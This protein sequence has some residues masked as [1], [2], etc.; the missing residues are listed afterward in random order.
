[1]TSPPSAEELARALHGRRRGGGWLC[2]CP[3]HDDHHP[4]LSIAEGDGRRTL[5]KCWGGCSQDSVLDELR[6]RNLWPARRDGGTGGWT[7]GRTGRRESRA[8][9]ANADARRGSARLVDPMKPWRDAAPFAGGC[10][11]DS[12]L[13]SRG[14]E[15]AEHETS[16]LRSASALWHWPTG[17]HWPA[18]V[19]RA[20]LGD[21]VELAAHMT[22][23]RRDGSSK[24]PLG[25][26]V[27][28]FP[29][30]GRTAGGGVWFGTVED[31]EREF[32]VGEGIESTLSAMRI[33]HCAA[34]CAA[35]S[36]FGI[37][38]LVLP[39]S[40]RRI[41]IF[42]DHDALGQGLAAARE[43]WRRWRA[44]GREVA[45]SI[46]SSAGEDANDVWRRRTA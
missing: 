39:A 16:N 30:G 27:R 19:A 41:R 40:V 24:A 18:M 3:A 9:S 8:A 17:T 12:Y 45:V 2:K 23:L 42:A 38:R 43:A 37:R 25:D 44:E 4:S 46:A 14:I 21:G 5:I 36:E 11:V 6:R 29:A 31:P 28:L 1:M 15:L 7:D 26:K 33:F 35:L 32:I 13:R 22:F 20:H 10:V 34:G